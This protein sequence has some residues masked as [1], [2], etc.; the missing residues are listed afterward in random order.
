MKRISKC[1]L[2]AVLFIATCN[3]IVHYGIMSEKASKIFTIEDYSNAK[4]SDDSD[5][6]KQHGGHGYGYG[7]GHARKL[8]VTT[9]TNTTA[10]IPSNNGHSDND[11][12]TSSSLSPPSQE[13]LYQQYIPNPATECMLKLEKTH[14][15]LMYEWNLADKPIL[16]SVKIVNNIFYVLLNMFDLNHSVKKIWRNG[17]FHCNG[18]PGGKEVNHFDYEGQNGN[19]IIECPASVDAS[20]DILKTFSVIPMAMAIPTSNTTSRTST[21]VNANVTSEWVTYE[22]ELFDECERKDIEHFSNSKNVK[23]GITATVKGNRTKALEWA[24]YHHIIGVDHIWIYINEDWNNATDI[25]HR[26]YITWIPYNFN[27]QYTHE[28]NKARAF[29]PHEVFRIASQNDALWRAKRMGLEW[30]APFDFDE[31]IDITYPTMVNDLPYDHSFGSAVRESDID[32]LPKFLKK[33]QNTHFVKYPKFVGIQMKSVPLGRHGKDRA[34]GKETELTIDNV[35]RLKGAI[36]TFRAPR[37]KL[38]LNVTITT[39]IYNLHYLGGA[40][41]GDNWVWRAPAKEIRVNHYKN[42]QKGVFNNRNS[43]TNE[44]DDVELHTSFMEKYH[45]KLLDELQWSTSKRNLRS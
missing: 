18:A 17:S 10:E 5:S 35:W 3:F 33:F 37:C 41:T 20:K 1:L 26:D 9:I 14:I 8:D 32:T 4:S 19:L 11:S 44:A 39:S 21:P 34:A 40:S 15:P 28:Y 30:I 2:T 25:V 23:I 7:H 42:P 27:I 43:F 13:V 24:A 16:H 31:Y 45:T 6:D 12:S 22:T 36:N 38:I 29:T